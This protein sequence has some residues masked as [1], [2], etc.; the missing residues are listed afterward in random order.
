MRKRLVVAGN[1]MA[2]ARVLEE[3]LALAPDAYDIQVFGAEPHGNYNRILLSSMLA[4]EKALA[5]IVT[6]PREW[7]ASRGIALHTGDPVVAVDRSRR[8]ATTRN[9]VRAPYD[10]LLLATGSKPFVLPVPGRELPGVVAFRDIADVGHM[11]DASQ[12]FSEAVIIGG[13]LLGL[14]CAYGLK[15]RGMNVTVIH[16]MDRL[17]ERQ[18][19]ASAAKLLQAH[20]ERAGVR[21]LLSA[22]TESIVGDGRVNAVRL[23]DGRQ[24]PAQLVVMAAG[25]VPNLD[26]PKAAGLPCERG[27]LV[28]DTL[29]TFDPRVYAVGECV[30]HRKAVYGLVAPLYE[31]AAVC[32]NHLAGHGI[33]RYSG[34]VVHTRLKV[35][36][37]ELFSAGNFLG[38]DGTRD[39]VYRDGRRG[40]YKRLVVRGAKLEG[41]IL[42]GD[43][44]DGGW[45]FDLI[46]TR[47]DVS[48]YRDLLVFGRRHA[49]AACPPL[50]R[51]ARTAGW[52][53]ACARGA[54]APSRS[55]ATRRIP[56]IAG[57]CA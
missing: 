16:L 30:Q 6:H 20:L 47:A 38:G 12:R 7:Y 28:N 8:V 55:P 40:I 49:E 36:G 43:A 29:Q 9:G 45:Y 1:G 32:A 57:A 13:G 33:G 4:G 53:V 3:L 31:Q 18:L 52:A 25:I 24:I 15:R 2:A 5:D 39:I 48:R 51:P 41:A 23:K 21:V 37:V 56:R 19:D 42:Y 46:N 11:L 44:A 26:L 22:Q 27:V 50:R 10:R 34:S 14:E 54:A 17:M 35:T